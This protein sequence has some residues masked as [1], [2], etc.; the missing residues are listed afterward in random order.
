MGQPMS[1]EQFLNILRVHHRQI[2]LV[3]VATLGATLAATL[4]QPKQYTASAS[5]VVDVKSPDPIAG[6]ILPGLMAPGYMATQVDII[7]SDRVAGR[8]V[9]L[10]KLDENPRVI[11]GWQESTNGRGSVTAWLVDSLQRHLEVKPSRESSVIN[12]AFTTDDGAS[13]AAAANAFAQAY[14]DATIELRVEP[15][16]QYAR[17]FDGQI[18]TQRER[19]EAAQKALS[20]YQQKTGIVVTDER[21]DFETQKL[22]DLA[23]QLTQTQGQ[24]A[25]SIGKQKA[26]DASS[27]PEVIQSP[28]I[29]QLKADIARQEGKLGELIGKLGDNHPQLQSARAELAE[30]KKR[31]ASETVQIAS[32]LNSASRA[33]RQKETEIRAALEAQKRKILELKRQ[34]DEISVLLREVDTEQKAFDA[35]SQ[36]MAQSKLESESIQTNISILTPASEP[37]TPSKPLLRKNLVVAAFVGTLLGIVM[38]LMIEFRHRRVRSAADLAQFLELPVLAELEQLPSTAAREG[39]NTRRIWLPRFLALRRTAW[40]GV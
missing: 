7:N 21:L 32:S 37:L 20:E 26:G 18:R 4:L 8:V 35:I 14:I 28:L 30:M 23:T 10:L 27:L 38:A 40:E 34:R 29:N 9:K 17:W 2:V 33:S 5:V 25:E 3:L 22:N 31:L 1:I 19:L 16:R 6:I 39:G 24:S 36:R 12:I 11:Q 13:A 15:A